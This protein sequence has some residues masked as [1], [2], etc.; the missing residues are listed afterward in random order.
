MPQHTKRLRPRTYSV[1]VYLVVLVVVFQVAMLISVFWMR[2][3]VVPVNFQMPVGRPGVTPTAMTVTPLAPGPALP[4]PPRLSVPRLELTVPHLAMLS[5]PSA[6]DRLEQIGDL[7]DDAQSFRRKNDL[8]SAIASLLKA[9]DL[10]PRNPSTLKNLAE[11]YYLTNDAMLA[12]QYWQR[13]ADLGPGV[14]TVY[15]VAKDHVLLLDSTHDADALTEPSLLQRTI[16]IDEVTKT[17]VDTTGGQPKFDV[18]IVLMR[19][20]P[21]MPD[22][23]Q[24]KIRPFVIFYQQLADGSLAPDLGKHSGGFDD[25]LLFRGGRFKEPFSVDYL[26][27]VTGQ[28]GPNHTT[29]GDYYGFIIAI[30]YDNILQDARSEPA[31]LVLRKP[32]PTEIE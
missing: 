16:Y 29:M 20:D 7:N 8:K 13:L 24:K 22:F 6:S 15:G 23:D 30:Y 26:M 11:T 31:D 27:P 19:R 9:E 14:G 3:M 4:A 18:R 25:T 21:N 32:L 28:P 2:A 5:I 1:A 10:D 17:P 12:K